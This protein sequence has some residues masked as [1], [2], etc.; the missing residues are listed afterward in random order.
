MGELIVDI[1]SVTAAGKSQYTQIHDTSQTS[2]EEKPLSLPLPR[3]WKIRYAISILRLAHQIPMEAWCKE[4]L[5]DKNN[6][7]NNNNNINK[8]TSNWFYIEDWGVQ[9]L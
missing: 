1:L 3:D 8:E 7:N 2:F 9:F 6:N 5:D 4:T